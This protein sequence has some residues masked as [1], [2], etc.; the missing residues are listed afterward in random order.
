MKRS[1]ASASGCKC[2]QVQPAA[3]NELVIVSPTLTG[4]RTLR[5]LVRSYWTSLLYT[6]PTR[7]N[8]YKS[9]EHNMTSILNG[10]VRQDRAF[11]NLRSVVSPIRHLSTVWKQRRLWHSD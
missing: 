6:E 4:G 5:D 9:M 3:E 10:Q 2:R 1:T 11:C 7:L 8:K